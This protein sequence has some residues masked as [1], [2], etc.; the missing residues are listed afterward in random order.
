L[1]AIVLKG[2]G[3]LEGESQVRITTLINSTPEAHLHR[4]LSLDTSDPAEI[5]SGDGEEIGGKSADAK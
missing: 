3:E 1:A 4:Y 5:E 2:L